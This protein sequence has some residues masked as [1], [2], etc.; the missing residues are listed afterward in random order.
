MTE[1]E[2]RSRRGLLT[3]Q[4]AI[5]TGAGNGIGRGIAIEMARGEQ[6]S[7]LLTLMQ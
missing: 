5:V 4:V 2:G 6:Q 3:K 7:S 1:I